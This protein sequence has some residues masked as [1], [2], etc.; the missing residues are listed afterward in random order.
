MGATRRLWFFMRFDAKLSLGFSAR[1]LVEALLTPALIVGQERTVLAINEQARILL[2][3]PNGSVLNGGPA[4]DLFSRDTALEIS[5]MLETGQRGERRFGTIRVRQGHHSC[6]MSPLCNDAGDMLGVLVQL[7]PAAR[8]SGSDASSDE[9]E[10]EHANPDWLWKTAILNANQAVWDHDFELDRHFL[11]D[12]WHLLRGLKPGD[13][14]I[15]NTEDWLETIHPEDLDHIKEELRRIDAGETDIVNYK[16]RQRHA[17]G[18]WVWFLSVGRIVRRD[19]QGLPARMIGTDTD[20]SDIKAA[21]AERRRLVDQLS[22]AMQAAD[23]RRWEFDAGPA[24]D[25]WDDRKFRIYDASGACTE[26]N[27]GALRDLVHPDDRDAL[28]DYT[29][30]RV[31]QRKHIAFDYRVRTAEGQIRQMRSRG[32]F[33]YD[34]EIGGQ[35][36]GVTIDITRDFE[37][38]EELERARAQMEHDSRH[39]AL[40]GLANRRLLDDVFG[41]LCRDDDLTHNRIAVMHFDIDHF[42]DINDT[43][44][45]DAG[46]ATLCHAAD[47]LVAN[48]PSDALVARVGGDEFVALI[49]D[50]DSD[51]ALEEMA[52]RI[53][54]EMAEPFYYGAQQCN[55]GTSIGIAV[56]QEGT[57]LGTELFI[58]ADLALYAAKKEGRGRSRFFSDEM[59]REARTRKSAFDNLL[60]GFEQN[61]IIC[62]FQPQF[63]AQTLRLTGMEALVR[64]QSETLGLLMPDAFLETAEEMGLLAKIDDRVLRIALDQSLK[65]RAMGLNVPQM[66]VNVSA[67]RLNDPTLAQTLQAMNLPPGRIVFE[68]LES[69]FLDSQNDIVQRNLKQIRGMGLEIEI[70]DFGSGHASIVSLLETAPT[71]LKIDRSLVQPIHK[72]RRQRDLV[73][74]IV[75]IG[76]M[77]DVRVVAEGVETPDHVRILR[78]LGCHYLQGYGLARPMP[79]SDITRLLQQLNLNGGTLRLDQC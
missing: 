34:L 5:K 25:N 43:L 71:R 11:S 51:A 49:P 32:R 19:K 30:E 78:D 13:P 72:S 4:L 40:T 28:F 79:A 65:W 39:D 12:T 56:A 44:G 36:H 45:H 41:N 55:Y 17:N 2:S 77:L 48:T 62:H 63:D 61:E 66:S 16:F 46:D 10:D 29:A 15:K 76:R 74:T 47:V 58:D 23:M 8:S 42:K 50:A 22:V 54:T 57:R 60:N 64:W 14:V 37:R 70:D 7:P 73:K 24:D 3:V 6:A 38:A 67:H 69:A 68:L 59:R 52:E 1:P 26:A 21:E 31:G 27:F 75:D 18:H 9:I 53:I 20:I 33:L 35:Y